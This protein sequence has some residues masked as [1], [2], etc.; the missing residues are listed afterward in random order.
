MTKVLVTDKIDEE[1]VRKI[2]EFADVEVATGLKPPELIEKIKN[3]D[4]IVVRSATKVTKE[5][6]DAGEN[7]KVI[8]RAGAGL[9]NV[10][11]EAAKARGIKVLNT[12]EAPSVA[13]AEL[14]LGLM[15]SWVRGIPKAD[16]GMKHGK[17]LKSE[18]MGTE[19]RGK[20]LGII[21][22]GKIGREVGYRAKAFTMR[23]LAYDVLKNEEF[24]KETGCEYVDLEKLLAESDF[25]SIHIPL[26]PSTKHMIGKAQLSLMKPTSVIVNTSR[27]EIVDEAA[28]IEALKGGKV[29]G[30]CLDVYS[31]EPL[32]DSPLVNLPNVV[33]TPHIGASTHE[34]QREA[35]LLIADKIKGA[36]PE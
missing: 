31:R 13:V 27:G 25:V 22:T 26:L 32:V 35:A 4:V 5:V 34:T 1:G 36:I 24:V 18:L 30:A 10:D 21:G 9:D 29:A 20:T 8:A 14:A 3:Y 7:L 33:L 2:R 15:L 28:L 11:S 19:L 17:W 6:I 23:L 16:A 12:P